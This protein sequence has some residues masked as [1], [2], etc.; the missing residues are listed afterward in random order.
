MKRKIFILATFLVFSLVLG[1]CSQK[2]QKI[3]N[4]KNQLVGGLQS[5]D[6]RFPDFGQPER[7]ADLRGIVKSI[8]GNGATVLKIDFPGGLSAS[9]TL[10]GKEG[11]MVDAPLEDRENNSARLSLGASGGEGPMMGGGGPGRPME[12][13]ESTRAKILETLKEMSTGEEKV[14]IPVGIKMLKTNTNGDKR[15]MIEASLVDITVDKN[16]TIW[17]NQEITDRS[18]AEFVIIN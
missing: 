8:I 16:I 2:D 12:R 11:S 15:E 7:T 10:N 13:D 1:G 4:D 9:S 6:R 18:V 5:S 3:S 14:I 17:L